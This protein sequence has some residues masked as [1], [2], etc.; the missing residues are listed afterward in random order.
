MDA[1]AAKKLAKK[2]E[3]PYDFATEF[4][5]A[6]SSACEIYT[7]EPEKEKLREL[8]LNGAKFK[9]GHTKKKAA[10]LQEQGWILFCEEE[11]Y[12]SYDSVLYKKEE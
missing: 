9:I 2:F 12:D 8:A 3:D 1:K 6:T 11:N 5:I 7:S 10:K 4:A